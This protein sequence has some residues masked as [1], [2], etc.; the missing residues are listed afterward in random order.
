MSDTKGDV[1]CSHS[2]SEETLGK[3]GNWFCIQVCLIHLH[4]S[5]LHWMIH[6]PASKSNCIHLFVLTKPPSSC[7]IARQP[8]MHWS[9]V[10]FTYGRMAPT[11]NYLLPSKDEKKFFLPLPFIYY[12]KFVFYSSAVDLQ[13]C[14][15]FS[16]TAKRF[17]YIWVF[18]Q[19]HV[20]LYRRQES[21]PSP[22][23]RNAKRKNG[24]LRRPYK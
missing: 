18:F 21:R 3:K 12:Y 14:G 16:C 19:I 10:C 24:C 15:G 4:G 17:S 6:Q 1:S 20:T 23:K 22:R 7:G 9:A 5:Q 11:R 13:C 8:H 2:V